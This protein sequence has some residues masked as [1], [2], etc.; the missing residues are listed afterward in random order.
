ME[1][2]ICTKCEIEKPID[3]F[4]W[5]SKKDNKRRA[6]CRECTREDDRLKYESD[7]ERRE[8]LRKTATDR[9]RWAREFIQRVKKKLKCVKCGEN[10]WYVLEFHHL[11]DKE[12]EV[13]NMAR[14]GYSINKI[15]DEIRKCDVLCANCHRE[16]HFLNGY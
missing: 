7:G 10:R 1:T 4:N 11:N 13:G 8:K 14:N 12:V 5:K 15:K 3:E 2:K 9:N 6:R 16:E